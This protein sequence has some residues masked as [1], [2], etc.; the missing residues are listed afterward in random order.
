MLSSLDVV[1]SVTLHKG[2]AIK[3]VALRSLIK[4]TMASSNVKGVGLFQSACGVLSK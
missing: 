4:S 1:A 3:V 2:Y